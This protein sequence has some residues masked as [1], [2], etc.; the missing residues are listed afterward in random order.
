MSI[1]LNVCEADRVRDTM[2]LFLTYVF[3]VTFDWCI[4]DPAMIIMSI[5]RF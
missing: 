2:R 3:L 1:F 5:N 4:V